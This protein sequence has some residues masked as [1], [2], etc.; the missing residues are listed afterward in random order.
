MAGACALRR[1]D[2][3]L[4]MVKYAIC[5]G[6]EACERNRVFAVIEWHRGMGN[7]EI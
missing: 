3:R 4:D 1:A 6:F 5:A 2:L 7:V